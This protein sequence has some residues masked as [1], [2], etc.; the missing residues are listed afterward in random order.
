MKST[1]KDPV[2]SISECLEKYAIGLLMSEVDMAENMMLDCPELY[3]KV[4]HVQSVMDEMNQV[5]L[6]NLDEI[7]DN[8]KEQITKHILAMK[9]EVLE[10][11]IDKDGFKNSTVSI[12]R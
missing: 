12:R 2:Y 9:I 5:V 3:N 1:Y 10:I 7:V 6:D 8:F 4:E 11:G